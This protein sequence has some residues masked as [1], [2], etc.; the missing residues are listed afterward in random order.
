MTKE[1]VHYT[2]HAQACKPFRLRLTDGSLITVPH[3][4]FMSISP[5]GRTAVVNTGGEELKI[6]DLALVTAIEVAS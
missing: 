4:G 3:A 5:G 2:L 6:A 1:A